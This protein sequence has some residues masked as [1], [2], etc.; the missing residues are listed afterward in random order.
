[1]KVAPVIRALREFG[2][3]EQILIHTGQHYD[4]ALS[5]EFFEDLELPR[6]NLNLGVG[7]GSHATQ[8]G[9]IMIALEPALERIEPDWVFTVG[10]VNST[11]AAA[12]VAAKLQIP[13][14]HVEAGLRSHDRSMPEEINRTLTD[15]ISD[16]LFTTEPSANEN[17]RQ[18]GIGEEK[19]HYVGNVMIDSLDYYLERA[20]ELDIDEALGLDPGDYLLVTLHRPINVD[21]RARLSGILAALGEVTCFH[22]VVFPMHP[23]TARNVKQFEL[24]EALAPISVLGPVRYLEFLALMDRAGAVITD[25]GGIQ[26]ET[27]VLGVPCITLRPHTERPITL[28]EGTNR[29]FDGD[30]NDLVDVVLQ[31]VTTERRPHRP[32]LWDG[33]AAQR[34][35]R[36]AC[37]ELVAFRPPSLELAQR[38][39]APMAA[40]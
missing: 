6:P 20:R 26:E 27:T 10:D 23:R 17:L 21:G 13:V 32:R 37:D 4:D 7:S 12:L 14:A 24:E 29:I 30:L 22:P 11:L 16:A 31:A 34:I 19:I 3:V 40:S 9:R 18:E 8:T 35:A 38:M 28:L 2:Q 33:N 1:M 25:S 39:G 15:H 5:A 36:I